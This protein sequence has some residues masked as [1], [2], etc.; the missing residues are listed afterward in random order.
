MSGK[1]KYRELW[2]KYYS[3]CTAILFVVDCSDR[4]R[5]CVARD[6]LELLLEHADMKTNNAPLL[7]LANKID[8]PGTITPQQCLNEINIHAITNR[9][10]HISSCNAKTG[11]GVEEGIGWLASKVA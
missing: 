9:F 3:E 10:W 5:M 8:L 6:E 1:V 7:I 4:I 11:E 2:E